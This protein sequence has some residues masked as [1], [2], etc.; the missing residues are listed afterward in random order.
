M[1]QTLDFLEML[2]ANPLLKLHKGDDIWAILISLVWRFLFI[3]LCISR[4]NRDI[5][6]RKVKVTSYKPGKQTSTCEIPHNK[7]NEQKLEMN[8]TL[9]F[10]EMHCALLLKLPKG[11]DIW[12]ILIS[13]VWKFS[14]MYLCISQ[15]NRDITARKVKVTSY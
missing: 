2:C 12:A 8:Q 10:L 3:Y 6:T 11:D 9:D 5:T 7:S 14:L 4:N 15:D 1:N 13:L